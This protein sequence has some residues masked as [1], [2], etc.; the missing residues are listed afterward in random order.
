MTPSTKRWPS[1]WLPKNSERKIDLPFSDWGVSAVLSGHLH[2]Y[3]RFNIN[4]IPY[5]ING[6]GGDATYEIREE[7]PESIIRFSEEDGALLIE[8]NDK[9]LSF[10]FMTTSEKIVD[11]FI[12]KK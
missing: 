6:L 8:A 10:K 4:G 9:E 12:L 3:E 7:N 5:I 1:E 2:L 11:N